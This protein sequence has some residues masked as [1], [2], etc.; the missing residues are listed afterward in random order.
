MKKGFLIAMLA[1]LPGCVSSVSGEDGLVT[2]AARS[3]ARSVVNGVVTEKF[4]GTDV[5]AYTD[6]VIDN[7]TTDE[8]VS[9]AKDGA[10]GDSA[11]AAQSVLTIAQ[12]SDTL[13]CLLS[14]GI[15]GVSL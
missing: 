7:A 1:L 12:R 5:S 13:T 11:G 4:P 9:L 8:L 10:T 15:G 14:A 2:Q 3:S 6:C